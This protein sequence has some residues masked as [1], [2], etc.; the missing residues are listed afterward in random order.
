[1]VDNS[2]MLGEV[3]FP[4]EVM[5]SLLVDKEGS[6]WRV[7]ENFREHWKFFKK[8]FYSID[9]LEFKIE[10]AL[11]VLIQVISSRHLDSWLDGSVKPEM[12]EALSGTVPVFDHC[13]KK[14][15]ENFRK[16]FIEK[17]GQ[18]G[19]GTLRRFLFEQFE[20]VGN[21]FAKERDEEHPENKIS[22]SGLLPP[23]TRFY[24]QKKSSKGAI[25][26][27]FC[28]E[29]PPERR[30]VTIFDQRLRLSFPWLC[31]FVCFKNGKFYHYNSD[32]NRNNHSAFW[33]FYRPDS[34][35][36]EQD[37]IFYSNLT[38]IWPDWP[39]RWCLGYSIPVIKLED[40]LWA[41]KLLDYFWQTN[42]KSNDYLLLFW[43]WAIENIPEVSS[44]EDWYELSENKP[45]KILQLPWRECKDK[46]GQFAKRV[47]DYFVDVEDKVEKS[48]ISDPRKEV[49][50]RIL[51]RSKER[52]EE[53]LVF[54]A[55]HLVIDTDL[56]ELS[57]EFVAKRL[58]VMFEKITKDLK[59]HCADAAKETAEKFNEA[60]WERCIRKEE[61]VR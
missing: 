24:W 22:F 1:M 14:G 55:G 33:V 4:R 3:T 46:L 35:K 44:L 23:R 34:V 45:D 30:T 54:L 8:K 50:E 36:S 39:H 2:K 37:A 47:L 19:Q 38:N 7:G 9:R 52:L 56:K 60:D 42:F 57:R 27:L 43:L 40:P 5:G 25:Y 51:E 28:L 13:M 10:E 18:E 59:P 17:L 29:Y 12:V 21:A 6:L 11:K 26:D 32:N 48:K 58:G 16:N 49:R 61:A 15:E 20:E 41:S 53:E 31:I